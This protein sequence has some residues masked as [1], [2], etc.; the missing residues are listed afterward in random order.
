MSF[1]DGFV[2]EQPVGDSYLRRHTG[3]ESWLAGDMRDGIIFCRTSFA[4]CLVSFSRS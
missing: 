4:V 3:I 2:P 1:A